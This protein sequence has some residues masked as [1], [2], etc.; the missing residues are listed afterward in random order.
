MYTRLGGGPVSALASQRAEAKAVQLDSTWGTCNNYSASIDSVLL[1]L[2]IF[3][4]YT[5]IHRCRTP[6]PMQ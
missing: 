1:P 2:I 5:E 3:K 6:K 4:P